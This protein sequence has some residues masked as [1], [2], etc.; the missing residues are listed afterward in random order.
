MTQPGYRPAFTLVELLVVVAIIGILIALLLPAV[1]AARES[2]RRGECANNLRNI[3]LACLNYESARRGLPPASS[4]TPVERDNSLGWQVSILPYLEENALATNID[5]NYAERAESLALANDV[6]VPQ[7]QCPSDPDIETER[8]RKYDIRVMSYAGVLGSYYS[9]AG[10]NQCDP[11][12]GDACVGD[13]ATNDFGPVNL[14]GLMVV[15]RRN[16]LRRATDGLSKTALVGERWYQLRTWTFGSF[17]QERDPGAGPATSPPRGPQMKTAVSSA[18]NFDRRYP[19]NADLAR[20]GYYRL[21][22]EG[23]RPALPAGAPKTI[24]YNNL[25]FGS[26][27]P[28]GTHFALGDGSVRFT[29]DALDEA[30]YLA[31]GSRNGGEVVAD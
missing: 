25:P 26:F 3:S 31:L 18:K 2:A 10:V 22:L 27:H 7:Y 17:Y 11:A 28:G 19:P 24:R 8:G 5:A 6:V 30:A 12:T 14:D 1:Q 9:R 29:T 15:D 20:V 16:P 23:D 13:D 21:H 4:N